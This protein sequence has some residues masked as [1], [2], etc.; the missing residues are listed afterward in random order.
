M[1]MMKISIKDWE[2][3]GRAPVLVFATVAS[4][5]GETSDE[6]LQSF[7]MEWLPQL[8]RFSIGQTDLDRGVFQ[9][10]LDEA[11]SHW[12]VATKMDNERLLKELTAAVRLMELRLPSNEVDAW[13]RA[14]LK[15]GV[16]VA[17]ASGGF[18]GL[19]SP[20]DSNERETLSK[21]R[22]ILKVHAH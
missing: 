1:D 8:K 3:I 16:D 17:R 20:V 2:Q 7:A 15:L 12:E 11:A 18:L 21:I 6:E 19:T 22:N 4:A 14:L 13:K 9:W 10:A 5:D